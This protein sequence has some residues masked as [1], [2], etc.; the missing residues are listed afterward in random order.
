MQL[1]SLSTTHR[2]EDE[3]PQGSPAQANLEANGSI[4]VAFSPPT[5]ARCIQV[6]GTAVAI[7][8]PKPGDLERARRHLHAFGAEAERIGI[9]AELPP[10]MFRENDLIAVTVWIEQVFDQT[11]GP[12][13]GKRL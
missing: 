2:N 12:S 6:K 9:P 8:E 7:G 1:I 11:P 13:A 5:I 10:R 3:A 4:A